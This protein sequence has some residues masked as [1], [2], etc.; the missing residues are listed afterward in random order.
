MLGF[1]RSSRPE[2]PRSDPQAGEDFF[3]DSL[4][5][6]RVAMG[7][8]KLVIVGHSLGG[9]IT[10]C[11]A[12]RYPDS[13]R[14]AVLVSPVGVPP[15]PDREEEEKAIK[16]RRLGWRFTLFR[17]LWDKAVTPQAL[18]RVLGP[19]GPSI[20]SKMLRRRF[21]GHDDDLVTLMA[22]Y[23]YHANMNGPASGEHA[24]CGILQV[25]AWARNPLGPRLSQLMTPVSFYYG[26]HDW[27]SRSSADHYAPSMRDVSVATLP[28]GHHLY[29]DDHESFNAA[30]AREF[31]DIVV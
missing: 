15:A 18:L 30:L 17:W 23:A 13:L 4:E 19:A 14:K 16:A 22:D 12:L 8:E 2:F 21:A 24:M 31:S 25:G 9:F 3:V 1:G 7:L 10:G 6:W 28:G 11:F 29:L 27:M 20:A 26:T 5:Q